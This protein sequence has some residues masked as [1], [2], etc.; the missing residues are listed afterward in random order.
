MTETPAPASA[1][2]R[3]R[4]DASALTG[5]ARSLLTAA[6]MPEDR[7]HD[8]A[9]ILVEADLLGH[10]T[11]GLQLL[12]T[13]LQHIEAGQMKLEGEPLT[14][15]DHGAVIAWDGQ[16]LPGPWLVLRAME[17][18]TERA[19]LYGSGTVT[20]GRSH[21]IACLAAYLKRATDSGLV[22]LLLTSAP[23]GASVAPYGGL[24]SVFSPSP[25]AIGFPTAAGPVL[26]DVSTS[27][28]TNG[29]TNRL[30]K[31]GKRLPH[32][33]LIDE[34]G[35]PSDDP[36]VLAAP[37]K[38]TIL[39]LGGLDAGHKGYGLSLLVEAL[40]AGLSGRGRA[41]PPLPLDGSIFL[42]ILDPAAFSGAE[43]FHRQMDWVVNA[44]VDNPPRNGF[45][46]VRL[47]GQNGLARR[48]RQLLEGVELEPSI[49][50]ALAPWAEKFHVALPAKL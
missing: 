16:R 40:T 44:C 39:P 43:A 6:R 31:E 11:H 5:F 50:P 41:D 15:A 13:Y 37:H 8:V 19:K 12:S 36:A 2:R 35:E 9:A 4:H 27:I 1:A 14:L 21:H 24:R 33:W 49:L 26:V 22:M 20:I 47:P 17:I 48:Q 7:A 29:M 32:Q 38:G 34:N 46:R 10:D 45:D 42:Q 23:S 18:A 28:T 25:I 30:R 3:A